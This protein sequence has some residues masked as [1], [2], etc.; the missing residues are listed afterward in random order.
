MYLLPTDHFEKLLSGETVFWSIL[1]WDRTRASRDKASNLEVLC[2]SEF[3]TCITLEEN[4]LCERY[5]KLYVAKA[6]PR[7]SDG[8]V[9]HRAID[10]AS[11]NLRGLV[12]T[13]FDCGRSGLLGLSRN[14]LTFE[15]LLM[16]VFMRGIDNG[17]A[18]I[19]EVRLA[20]SS[21]VELDGDRSQVA[22][23]GS[24]FGVCS[25]LS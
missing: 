13:H 7:R 21:T 19:V 16:D 17:V 5:R 2:T 14:C 23:L 22:E 20:C 6:S 25:V 10:L 12:T 8:V 11:P 18:G 9:V 24:R 15:M 4:L 1:Q 3:C